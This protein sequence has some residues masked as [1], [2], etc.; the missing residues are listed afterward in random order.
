MLTP[1][2]S[3]WADSCISLEQIPEASGKCF[4]FITVA[5][6]HATP[7]AKLGKPVRERPFDSDVAALE[8]ARLHLIR[9]R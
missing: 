6:E 4:Y 9:D 7:P 8:A 3:C 2:V 1:R 5:S